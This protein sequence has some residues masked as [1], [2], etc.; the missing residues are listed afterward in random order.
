MASL[1][2]SPIQ[3]AQRGTPSAIYPISHGF[4][5]GGRVIGLPRAPRP[6]LPSEVRFQHETQQTAHGVALL[7]LV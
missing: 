5:I 1:W 2:V 6:F 3:I 7:P 4:I